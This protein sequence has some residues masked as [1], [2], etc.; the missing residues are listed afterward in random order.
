[1][2]SIVETKTENIRHSFSVMAVQM[3]LLLTV[4]LL[5]A[6]TAASARQ[7]AMLLNPPQLVAGSEVSFTYDSSLTPLKGEQQVFGFAYVYEDYQWKV[8][9]VD[10]QN[11]GENLWQGTFLV[12]QG[13]GFVAMK[14][15]ETLNARAEK[16]D[17]N[18]DQGYL[19]QVYSPK[20][21]P[22]PG[23]D[24]GKAVFLSR[25]VMTAPGYTGVGGYFSPEQQPADSEMLKLLIASEKKRYPKNR[26]KYFYEEVNLYKQIYGSE[27][28]AHILQTLKQVERDKHLDESAYYDLSYAYLFL[29]SD[30]EKS[31]Q[32]DSAM[33]SRFPHGRLARFKAIDAL[34]VLKGDEYF[35]AAAEVRRN[36]PVEKYY[37]NKDFQGFIYRNF[38]RRLSQELFDAGRYGELEEVLKEMDSG[39]LEDAFLHQPKQSMKFPDRDPHKYYAIAN[40]YIEEMQ[41][42]YAF[43]GNADGA[44]SSPKQLEQYHLRYLE[45]YKTVMTTLAYRTA[46]YQEGADMM[47]TIPME[48]RFSYDPNNNE[49][50]VNCLEKLGRNAEIAQSLQSSASHS[51]LTP[52][53]LEQLKS[54]YHSLEVK[55]SSSFDEYLYSLKTVEAKAEILKEVKRGLVSDPFTPFCVEDINGGSVSSADFGKDDIVVLDFWAMW[56]SPCCAAL[57]GMQMAVEKYIHDP[58]VKFFF[59]DTQDRATKDILNKYWNDKGY[60]DMLIVFDQDHPGTHD[61]ALL[62]SDM[63]P[64]TSGIPQKAILKDGKVRYRASGYMGS[65]SGLMDEISAVIELLKN[66]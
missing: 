39:T 20:K 27:A 65:P 62:Y 21:Q 57:V 26:L 15:Q 1:M 59:V 45:Y 16:T 60:H 38:Y 52:Y 58:H 50:Y 36:F 66:E 23:A 28:E 42:K 41:K 61:G 12:P 7:Q 32:I 3:R 22:M 29:M 18:H 11:V 37:E 47:E 25:A 55:P 54:Y 13:A 33:L 19:Y 44:S 17:N 10:M 56:C 43:F 24:I 34:N 49:A 63:F 8:Y 31:K 53:L 6:L 64:G 40:K 46:H 4:F 35:N 14:F 5:S 9:D 51:K 2:M 48:R 30:K